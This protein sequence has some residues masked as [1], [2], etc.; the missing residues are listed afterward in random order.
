M[1][2]PTRCPTAGSSIPLSHRRRAAFCTVV[3]DRRRARGLS[4]LTVANLIGLPQQTVT[5]IEAGTDLPSLD[6][7]FALADV[8][9][10]D[11]A[12]LLHETRVLANR[13]GHSAR[14]ANRDRTWPTA[15][16]P[17]FARRPSHREQVSNH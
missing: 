1:T 10:T 2:T 4:L 11:P 8:L 7:L 16:L 13:A 5:D 9:G 12:E 17:I 15:I 3:Q 14:D 6:L